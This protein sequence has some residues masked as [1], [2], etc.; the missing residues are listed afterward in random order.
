MIPVKLTI[1]GLYSYQERQTI[2]FS[3]LIETGLFGIFGNV[4][5]GK[6][7]ILEAISYALYGETERLNA[8]DKRTYNMMNLKSN[9]SYIEF[10]FLNFDNCLFRATR[11][12][13]RNSKNFDDVRP[14]SVVFYEW[15]NTQW[16]PLEN[17]DTEKIIGLSYTNFKRTII[18]PQGQFKEFLELGEADRTKMMKEI[19][20]LQRYDLY[21]KAALLNKTNQTALYQ[22]EGQ[23][24]G[25]EE[26]SSEKIETYKNNLE[27]AKN[28]FEIIQEKHQ[29]L[30]KSVQLLKN[31]KSD[32]ELLK[33]KK[34][35]F[36]TL[37]KGKATIDK[38]EEQLKL[39]QT[40]SRTFNEVLQNKKRE[41]YQLKIVNEQLTVAMEAVTFLNENL[42][43]LKT[44]WAAIQQKINDLPQ[45]K[46]LETDFELILKIKDSQNKLEENKIRTSEGEKFVSI[47]KLKES[48]Y[49]TSIKDSEAVHEELKMKLIP[50]QII[51]SAGEWFSKF[52]N[53][54]QNLNT[55]KEKAEQYEQSI[56][57]IN[58]K[59]RAF[60]SEKIFE[61]IT[62]LKTAKQD[63]HTHRNQLE[64][65]RQLARFSDGLENEKPC[66]LCG[67]LHHPAITTFEDVSKELKILEEKQY[68]IDENLGILERKKEN[69][70]KLQQENQLLLSHL[71]LIENNINTLENQINVLHENFIWNEFISKDTEEF[72]KIK[73]ENRTLEEAIRSKENELS[74]LRLELENIRKK[75]EKAT[76]R[77]QIINEENLKFK[78]ISETNQKQ[79]KQINPDDF[80]HFSTE[81]IMQK[82]FE[83]KKE[84][85][86]IEETS[87]QL[88]KKIAEFSLKLA[89]ESAK[90]EQ[91]NRQA[92]NCMDHLDRYQKKIERLLSENTFSTIQEVLDILNKPLNEAEIEKEIQ[93]FKILFGTLKKEL[94]IIEARL[95]DHSF[96]EKALSETE[97]KLKTSEI[98]LKETND[99][100]VRIAAELNRLAI[101][102]KKKE[103]LFLQ[104]TELEKRADDL[105]TMLNLF[106]ASG[107]V[108][109]VSSIYLRQLCDHANV[110]FHRMTRNQLSLQLNDK[111]DFEIIDYLNEGRS[112]SVKTL[113]GG[114]AFQASLSLALA[115]AESV[116]TNAKSEK[117]F[118][119]IDEG[120]G[121]QDAD[122][123]T[124]VFE[125][126]MSLQKENRIVGIISHVDELKDRIPVA[127]TIKKDEERGSLI[128]GDL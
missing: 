3:A 90:Q 73:K 128:S 104:Y 57:T 45:Q 100:V 2:D 117:N 24:K 119:F 21:D 107:F 33:E 61:K 31:L 126:L 76:V 26:I 17:A 95:K 96:D 47:C 40:T 42:N 63:L 18:I 80:L 93:D 88:N 108:Q 48:E 1:E 86:S 113:S 79:L 50:V 109:Y 56:L 35:L 43:R 85:A 115:L 94:E 97:F 23:L 14:P 58:E 34:E 112:R 54:M 99:S 87:A 71:K 4:G 19:F 41:E 65:S 38:K 106:K 10:D 66:P 15:K 5:S 125:T 105:K 98:H 121:T 116:Q 70:Q 89:S 72:E 12:F 32:F 77:F 52:Q 74:H 78:T 127:L 102:F 25:F 55:E 22:L 39:Y 28:N 118:F 7:S 114:Q 124:T 44:D 123:V 68:K 37:E 75:L 101:E 27:E 82:L 69:L 91:L 64:V 62:L 53:T 92:F 120:F 13:K 30:Y 67:S 122:S 81:D 84:N 20:G 111:G 11:E 36:Y 46:I 49:L 16:I 51:V 83:L 8:R 60:E 9:R 59:I 6:S 110:R 29:H 103:N